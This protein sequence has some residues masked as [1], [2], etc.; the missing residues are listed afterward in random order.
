MAGDFVLSGYRQ[1]VQATAH[2]LLKGDDMTKKDKP[3]RLEFVH[4][5]GDPVNAVRNIVKNEIK[6]VLEKN[7]AVAYNLDEV[8]NKYITGEIGN[9]QK[10]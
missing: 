8:I 7:D 3:Y 10:D 5:G 9:E 2:N 6:K 1:H 4:N